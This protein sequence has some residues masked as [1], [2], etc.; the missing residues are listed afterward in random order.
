VQQI[1]SAL[2]SCIDKFQKADAGD[3]K[4]QTKRN[5]GVSGGGERGRKEKRK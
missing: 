5:D 3:I 4:G 2:I 1:N